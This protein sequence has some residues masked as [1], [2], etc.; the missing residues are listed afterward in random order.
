MLNTIFKSYSFVK[1]DILFLI[2][3]QFCLNLIN[4]SFILIF[5]IY[6]AKQGMS[7]ALIADITSY[8]FLGVLCCAFPLGLY[9]KGR[10][11]RPFFFYAGCGMPII[12]FFT[13]YA[14]YHQYALMLQITSFL[15]GIFFS[16]IQIVVLPFI[17]RNTKSAQQPEAIA[18]HHA[19]FSFSM[20]VCSLLI[21]LF[22][23]I[24]YVNEQTILTAFSIMGFLSLYFVLRINKNEY[25]P[26]NQDEVQSSTDWGIVFTA[27]F[28]RIIIAVGAGLTIPYMNLFFYAV[29]GLDYD[30]FSL[31][32]FV[33]ASF[34]G[35]AVVYVPQLKKNYG[36]HASI[37]STQSAAIVVLIALASTDV[38]HF[39]F[40]LYIALFCFVVRQP[41]MN[42]AGPMTAYLTMEYVGEKNQEITSALASATWSGSWFLS[43]K[44]FKYLRTYDL[45][46]GYIFLITAGLYICGAIGYHILIVHF[47]R[48]S[49]PHLKTLA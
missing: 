46:Y 48:Q 19:T 13:L 7:D 24:P 17:V 38:F 39:P 25:I 34:V 6:L 2:C 10:A 41:L 45:S 27:L 21:F 14:A 15:M 1:K 32:N 23:N 49:L 36:L 44:L 20:V 40:A 47:E 8:R 9:I 12:A 3:A 11:L 29:H 18:L 42:M 30:A 37:V 22:G 16:C 5:N 43:G 4:T 26:Q 31:L 35:M 28:P 33:T